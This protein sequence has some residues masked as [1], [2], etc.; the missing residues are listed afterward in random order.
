MDDLSA[1]QSD[2]Q[3]VNC[4][5]QCVYDPAQQA[6][7]CSSC[8]SRFGLETA[9]DEA[10]AEE[11]PYDPEASEADMPEVAEA[12]VH[13]CQTCGG[14]VVFVGQTLSERCAYCDGPVVLSSSDTAYRTKA[15]IPFR[16]P[17]RDAQVAAQNWVAARWAA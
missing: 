13:H 16:V 12:R 9:N 7:V 1:A 15:L 14:D 11:F 17:D 8:A 2:L 10:A 5:S 6:L 4:G 3:C